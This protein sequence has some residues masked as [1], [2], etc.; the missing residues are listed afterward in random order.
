MI[1]LPAE[2]ARDRV[3]KLR[4]EAGDAH[5]GAKHERFSKDSR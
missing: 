5:F 2:L 4:V 3:R 1:F